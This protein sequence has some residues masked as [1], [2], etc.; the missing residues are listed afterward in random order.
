MLKETNKWVLNMTKTIKYSEYTKNLLDKINEAESKGEPKSKIQSDIEKDLSETI[1]HDSEVIAEI[2]YKRKIFNIYFAIVLI[3]FVVSYA[4]VA[5]FLNMV[6][7]SENCL[8]REGYLEATDRSIN[9][10]TI[11]I[12]IAATITQVGAAFFAIAKFLFATKDNNNN[13]ESNSKEDA[14]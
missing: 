10:K 14:K 4:M 9:T 6:F 3:I 8:I 11:S 12:I 13:G 7:E 2:K 5:Y 1:D